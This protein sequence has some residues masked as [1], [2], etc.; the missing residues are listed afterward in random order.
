MER[1]NKLCKTALIDHTAHNSQ[2]GQNQAAVSLLVKLGRRVVPEEE[3]KKF[4]GL[5][6]KLLTSSIVT[7]LPSSQISF[8]AATRKMAWPWQTTGATGTL[9][10]FHL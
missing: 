10:F 7:T 1:S 5:F 2:G 4:K 6:S 8:I 3:K 9:S